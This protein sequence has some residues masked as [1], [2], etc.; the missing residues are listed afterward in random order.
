MYFQD[1]FVVS[2]S[3]NLLF[4]RL[5]VPDKKTGGLKDP[6]LIIDIENGKF[7][8]YD[9][10]NTNPCYTLTEVSDSIFAF[11]VDET[12]YDEGLNALADKKIDLKTLKWYGLNKLDTLP[13]KLF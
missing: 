9:T 1:Y 3:K 13:K 6:I 10:H 12:Q 8:Y 11:E 7:S 2:N 5:S 4:F